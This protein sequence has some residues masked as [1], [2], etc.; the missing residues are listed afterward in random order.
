VW[1]PP[2]VGRHDREAHAAIGRSSAIS[3]RDR[4]PCPLRAKVAP[5]SHRRRVIP[6]TGCRELPSTEDEALPDRIG[7]YGHRIGLAAAGRGAGFTPSRH[8]GAAGLGGD[9]YRRPRRWVQIGGPPVALDTSMASRGVI[10]YGARVAGLPVRRRVDGY[11]YGVGA[12]AY[13]STASALPDT[14]TVWRA[15]DSR[16]VVGEGDRPRR[17]QRI[18]ERRWR[19][20]GKPTAVGGG[21]YTPASGSADTR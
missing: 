17:G 3:D 12:L 19:R 21:G 4:W 2:G 10:Q 7:G 5:C 1:A 16:A 14:T 13:T 20:P 15:A 8:H 9:G 6:W 11:Q 18:V